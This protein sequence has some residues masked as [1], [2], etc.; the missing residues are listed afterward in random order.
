MNNENW[1]LNNEYWI[2]NNEN[3]IRTNENW[4]RTNELDELSVWS[5]RFIMDEDKETVLNLLR[6]EDGEE[7]QKTKF[8]LYFAA[9]KEYLCPNLMNLSRD[10]NLPKTGFNRAWLKSWKIEY[11]F[12]WNQ[13]YLSRGLNL[14]RGS[15]SLNSAS[16]RLCKQSG[17]KIRAYKYKET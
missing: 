4:I 16:G 12:K 17:L 6:Y 8:N 9:F 7:M 13:L 15:N 14:I 10:L 2:L 11:N 5:C 1:I 3:W